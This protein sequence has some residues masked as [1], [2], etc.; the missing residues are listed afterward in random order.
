MD[1][2]RRHLIGGA[3]ASGMIGSIASAQGAQHPSGQPA[4]QVID[5]RV[6]QFAI[7]PADK[8][9][10]ILVGMPRVAPPANG[11]S[12][13]MA[14]DGNATFPTLWDLRET[15]APD[16]PVV[17]IGVGYPIETRNDVTR[18]WY[19][20]TSPG[21]VPVPARPDLRGPGDRPTGG[22]DEFLGMITGD[23][24]PRLMRDLPL[25][26]SDMT[27]YGHSLG[28]LFVLHTLF[29][30]PD[31]FAR[32]V[33]A[34]PSTWWNAGEVLREAAAFRG[35]VLAAGGR[36]DPARP[37]L[38]ASAGAREPDILARLTGLPGLDLIHCPHPGESHGSLID[39]SLGQAFDLHLARLSPLQ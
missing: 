10:R 30:R 2:G 20:L 12:V 9:W 18:R 5:Q 23:L 7:G 13:I 17:L 34:D 38:I 27:L 32:H 8:P 39:P 11:Y 14:L 26:R 33:A 21:K 37:L 1:L 36:L 35:G 16:A 4:R 6:S 19:D 29:T 24:L 3:I 22:Q 25:D 28:G 31:L 15:M